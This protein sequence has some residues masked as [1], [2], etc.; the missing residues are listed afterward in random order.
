MAAEKEIAMNSVKEFLAILVLLIVFLPTTGGIQVVD[1]KVLTAAGSK[2]GIAG[3]VLNARS[4]N[5]ANSFGAV[6]AVD[7]MPFCRVAHF[8]E[9]EEVATALAKVNNAGHVVMLR[10]TEP[11]G[12]RF[13]VHTAHFTEPEPPQEHL[14]GTDIVY[15]TGEGTATFVTGGKIVNP[16]MV[17]PNEI[18]GTDIE[19]GETHILTKGSV[20]VVPAGVP[21]WH[22]EIHGDYTFILIKILG[23]E[24]RKR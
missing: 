18:R 12:V 21:H 11:R 9:S 2:R 16:R 10:E 23:E 15:V 22:K 24:A 17:G 7:S 19:G 3:A 6:L 1:K 13:E 14:I 20:N 4:V 8:C 5:P